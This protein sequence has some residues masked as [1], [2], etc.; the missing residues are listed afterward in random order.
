MLEVVPSQK[1]AFYATGIEIPGKNEDD[2]VLKAYKLLKKDFSLP[3]LDIHLHKLIPIGAGLG[4]GSAD[5]AFM[6]KLLSNEFQ[7][8]LEDNILEDYA[9]QLG[10]DC[11]FFINNSPAI[12][13][14]TGT[15]LEPIDLDLSGLYL[16]VI[17]PGIHVSTSQA[18]SGVVPQK[19]ITDL[20]ELLL[21]KDFVRWQKELVNDFELSLFDQYSSLSAIKDQLYQNGA[22]YAS[23]S[24]SGSTMFG[25]F[26]NKPVIKTEE[27]WVIKEFIL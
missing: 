13:T 18:Y 21:T 26:T 9:S 4:G 25:L 17:N 24:G 23:M 20:T 22:V 16:L 8:F 27:N 1:T 12:A 7:L 14:G 19:S 11:T 2:I 15:A 5:A 10:S 3:H 6:L